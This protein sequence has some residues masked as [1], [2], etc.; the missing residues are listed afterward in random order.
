MTRNTNLK[1]FLF[2]VELVDIYQYLKKPASQLTFFTTKEREEER[3]IE[4][5]PRYKAITNPRTGQ[6]FSVVSD[7]Y[8]LVTNEEAV[9]LAKQC[10]QQLFDMPD[11]EQMTVFNITAPQSRSFCH[12]DF[13]HKNYSVNLWDREMWLP[14]LRLTNSYNRSRALRFDLGFCRALCDNGMIFERETIEYKFLHT[15]QEISPMGQFKVD[16]TRLK[17]LEA[18]FHASVDRLCNYPVPQNA[19]LPVY[20]GDAAT[21]ARERQRLKVFISGVQPLVD[22]YCTELGE[23]AYAVLSVVTDIASRPFFYSTPS[24]MVDTLQKRAGRW[25]GIFTDQLTQPGF[26]LE[27]YLDQQIFE[28]FQN[29]ENLA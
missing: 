5:I 15:R 18:S 14:Y 2:P 4:K 3:E 7:G 10:F 12:I 13:I 29:F 25:F 20:A 9:S 26:R 28:I 23:N 24:W 17:K 19:F 16:F 8:R 22:K 21:Q 11:S 27:N 1:E 6:V